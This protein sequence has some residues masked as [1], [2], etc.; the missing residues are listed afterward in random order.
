MTV[1]DLLAS[2]RDVRE[3]ERLQGYPPTIGRISAVLKNLI[4]KLYFILN[5]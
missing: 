5:I 1:K 4:Q 2:F 3:G